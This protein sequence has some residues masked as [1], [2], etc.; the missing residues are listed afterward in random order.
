MPIEMATFLGQ[1]YNRDV[2]PEDLVTVIRFSQIM[3]GPVVPTFE[4]DLF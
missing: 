1:L 2:D 3:A 4:G